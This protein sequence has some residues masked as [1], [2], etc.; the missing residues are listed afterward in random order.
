MGL[1]QLV[2][3]AAGKMDMQVLALYCFGFFVI[4]QCAII[5]YNLY[6]SPLARFPGSRLAAASAW[7]ETYYSLI[8]EGGGRYYLK[9]A[10]WHEEYGPIVRISPTELHVKDPEYLET[11]Y[12]QGSGIDKAEWARFMFSIP[13]SIGSTVEHDTHRARKAPLLSFFSKTRVQQ[14]SQNII[15]RL[16]TMCDRLESEYAGKSK[17]VNLCDLFSCF[18]ADIITRYAFGTSYNFLGYTDFISPFAMAVAGFKKAGQVSI[19]FPMLPKILN[20]VPDSWILFLRPSF[21]PVAEFKKEILRLIDI[22][23]AKIKDGTGEK[24]HQSIFGQL[25]NSDLPSSEL[26]SYRLME[27]GV[28]LIGAAIDTTKWA[29]V[30]TI[31]HILR[32]TAVLRRLRQ[33]LD[34]AI[35]DPARLPS[36]AALEKLPFFMACIEEGIRLSYGGFARSPR[37]HPKALQYG[38]WRIPPRTPISTDAWSMHHDEEIFPESFAYRPERWLNDPKAPSGKSLSRY[39][40]AFGKGTRVCLGMQ[41]AYAEMELSLAA[42]FRR[43]DFEL[44]ESGRKDVDVYSD[45]IGPAAHPDSVGPRVL[46]SIRSTWK[47]PNQT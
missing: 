19:Q 14:Q 33:E 35:P 30:V 23:K 34:G 43:F 4:Y 9:I 18:S 36:L 37:L 13:F 17:P 24:S 45:A 44:F 1:G 41:L 20:R 40:L 11:I 10:K 25:L 22:E 5:I 38:S 12:S 26:D 16:E 32:D 39:S 8:D 28:A 29:T 3:D 42:L 27:E 6:L 2:T 47:E 7:Y 31:V 15:A 21:A 46:L